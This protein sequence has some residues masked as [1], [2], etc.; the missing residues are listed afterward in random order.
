MADVVLDSS[1][2][3]DGKSDRPVKRL[4]D[5][6]QIGPILFDPGRGLRLRDRLRRH[7]TGFEKNG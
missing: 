1:R 7:R 3:R 4:L 6:E 2:D 5:N